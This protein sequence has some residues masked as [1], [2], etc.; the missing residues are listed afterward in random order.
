VWCNP[1]NTL[2]ELERDSNRIMGSTPI[3]QFN[4]N[5]QSTSKEQLNV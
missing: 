5:F 4:I 2:L 3:T 1:G